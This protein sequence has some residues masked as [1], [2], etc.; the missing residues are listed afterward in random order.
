M[1]DSASHG[2]FGGEAV[3]RADLAR[4]RDEVGDETLRRYAK[5]YLDL[6]PDRLDRIEQA[7]GAEEGAAAIRV[8]F[9]LRVSSTMLGANRLAKLI[10]GVEASLGIGPPIG[11]AARMGALRAEAETVAA[12]L[13]RALTGLG[14][15]EA[16]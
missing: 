11:G 12:A 3:G 1:T 4:V 16:G 13:R 7:I 6:L 2:D 15:P 9:D 8:M 10:A 5:A 14:R